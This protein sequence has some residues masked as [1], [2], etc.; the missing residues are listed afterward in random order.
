MGTG[1]RFVKL[2]DL[3]T[4]EP[5]SDKALAE[6]VKRVGESSTTATPT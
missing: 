2:F 6:A 1:D 3:T 5:L 4:S